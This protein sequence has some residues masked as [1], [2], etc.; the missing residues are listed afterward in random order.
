MC[1]T[2]RWTNPCAILD[3]RRM[4][5]LLFDLL[6]TVLKIVSNEVSSLHAGDEERCVSE[7][8]RHFFER[9]LG[10]FGKDGPEEES[11]REVTYLKSSDESGTWRKRQ[12]LT[13]KRM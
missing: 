11:V 12:E 3:M 1:L 6:N 2:G 13:M 7:E 9:A 10:G 4:A 8:V 5:L